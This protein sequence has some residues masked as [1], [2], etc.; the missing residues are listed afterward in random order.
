[1]GKKMII[2]LFL[3]AYSS[4]LLIFILCFATIPIS[5][6][7]ADNP[8]EAW[9]GMTVGFIFQSWEAG[10]RQENRFISEQFKSTNL[11][12]DLNI[13]KN[14]SQNFAASAGLRFSKRNYNTIDANLLRY[15]GYVLWQNN[16]EYLVFSAR[17]GIQNDNLISQVQDLP[18]NT[19]TIWRNLAEFGY[20]FPKSKF[21][22][23]V[24][25]EFFKS[26]D[27]SSVINYEEIRLKPYIKYNISKNQSVSSGYLYRYNY[28]ANSREGHIFTFNYNAR[29]NFN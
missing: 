19:S 12:S 24:F 1:M 28:S 26:F 23:L 15:Y 21:S 4:K 18:I 22:A 6:I 16:S 29:L 5:N 27:Q 17:S 3:N 14:I 13:A 8:S 20:N 25:C 2:A 7:L 9:T 10:F 11:F